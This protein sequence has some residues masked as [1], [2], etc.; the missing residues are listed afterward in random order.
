MTRNGD[1]FVSLEDRV[2][3]RP[4]RQRGAVHLDPR[5]HA[6]RS[7]RPTSPARRSTP[8]P[9]GRP[10]PRPRASPSA[11][12]RPTRR[13]ARRRRPTRP[14]SPTSCSTS[15]GAKP[16]PMRIFFRA[17]S[18]R[19]WQ[20]RGAAQPQSRALGGLRRAE[21]AGFPSV[22]VELGYLS[23]PQDVANM[24][25]PEWRAKT[26]DGDGRADRALLRRRPRPPARRTTRAL[27]VARSRPAKPPKTPPPT[28]LSAHGP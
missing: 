16:A 22:L 17:G 1:E 6:R 23:N 3:D 9:T 4:R 24:T 19:K 26:A 7:P 12:T 18:S 10:T 11:R 28:P 14:A 15:S 2:A 27:A 13:P 8:A 25:S 21:G 20:G 5:R